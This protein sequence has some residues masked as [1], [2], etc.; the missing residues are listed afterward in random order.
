MVCA[1]PGLDRMGSYQTNPISADVASAMHRD[2]ERARLL[3]C[4]S[5]RLLTCS[6]ARLL[7]CSS[8]YLLICSSARLLIC[9]SARLLVCLSAYLLV[10]SSA[11]LLVCSSACL[12]L[13]EPAWEKAAT[14]MNHRYA[15]YSSLV[16]TSCHLSVDKIKSNRRNQTEM[17]VG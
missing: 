11:Y 17:N 9:S 14:T 1:D 5:D 8:A 16:L 3:V 10:C 2:E 6:S 7:T 13:Q 12:P 4:L 15:C